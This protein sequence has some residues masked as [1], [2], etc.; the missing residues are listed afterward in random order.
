MNVGYVT[1]E[2][3]KN[4]IRNLSITLAAVV[5]VAVSLGLAG[6]AFLLRIAVENATERWQGGIEFV[7]FMNPEAGEQEIEAVRADLQNSPAVESI[8]FIDKDAALEEFRRLFSDEPELVE[9]VDKADLP[10]SFR[11]VPVDKSAAAVESLSTQFE[12]KPGV[13]EVVLAS[14]TIRFVQDLVGCIS[15]AIIF[16]AFVLLGV[17]AFLIFNTIRMAV[18]AR[19][20]EI[21]VMK[22][23]GATN[24]FIRVPFM[25]EG[26]FQAVLGAGLAVLG[27]MVVR[28]LFSDLCNPPD[29]NSIPLVAGF[30]V[31]ANEALLVYGGMLGAGCVVGALSAAIAVTGYLDV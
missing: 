11:V 24:S 26:F 13:R 5:T 12:G 28:P 14:R 9:S 1:R 31:D 15:S 30:I 10:T 2:T 7:V 25:L 21:E 17:S 16:V 20:R 29:A 23:V 19:R 27:L 18:F 22:L 4:L 8:E 6:A 3:G